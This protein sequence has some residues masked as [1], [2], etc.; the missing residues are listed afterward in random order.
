MSFTKDFLVFAMVPDMA[1]EWA[2]ANIESKLLF[3]LALNVFLLA[4]GCLMDIYSA[5]VVVVPLL[6]PLGVEFG[7]DPIHL[8]IIFL[9]NLELGYLTPPV[10]LNL[11]LS[12]YRFDR[13][14]MEVAKAALPMLLVLAISV[15]LITYIPA[16]T[17]FLPN[18]ILGESGA[19]AF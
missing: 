8:G 18:L 19:S 16:L 13:P 14:V 5:I 7:I 17:T 6:L 4:V 3:L 1:I 10:G 15:L 9:A 11:F 2:T 12:A